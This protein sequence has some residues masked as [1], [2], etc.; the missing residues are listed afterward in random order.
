MEID[1]D[2]I[3]YGDS[4][5]NPNSFFQNI[6]YDKRYIGRT[7]NKFTL[8]DH[9][10]ITYIYFPATPWLEKNQ[11]EELKNN[12]CSLDENAEVLNPENYPW[13]KKITNDEEGAIRWFGEMIEKIKLDIDFHYPKETGYLI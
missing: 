7:Y 2:K 5:G 4:H 10:E 9:K 12:G 3:E 1:F 6:Y 11:I 8:F 13:H